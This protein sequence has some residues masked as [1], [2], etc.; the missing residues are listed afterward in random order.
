MYSAIHWLTMNCS[1]L[2]NTVARTG[3]FIMINVSS[4]VKCN[5]AINVSSYDAEVNTIKAFLS[6]QVCLVLTN[7]IKLVM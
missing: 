2:L 7:I 4:A 6:M 1:E 5:A 3:R